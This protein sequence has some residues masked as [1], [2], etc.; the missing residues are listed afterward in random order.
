MA[1]NFFP[2]GGREAEERNLLWGSMLLRGA[3]GEGSDS[4]TGN[5]REAEEVC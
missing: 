3:I 2:L 4:E 5:P 1:N